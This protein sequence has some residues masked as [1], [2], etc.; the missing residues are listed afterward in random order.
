[1]NK[2]THKFPV[3]MWYP[4]TSSYTCAHV[5]T[6]LLHDNGML[7][8]GYDDDSFEHAQSIKISRFSECEVSQFLLWA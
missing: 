1:M 4:F 3:S 2:A 5:I 7:F 6:N 8:P